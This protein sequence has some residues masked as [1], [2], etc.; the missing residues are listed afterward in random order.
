MVV[1]TC[2]RSQTQNTDFMF[3]SYLYPN[4]SEA[5]DL[6][7]SSLNLRSISRFYILHCSSPSPLMLVP[8][9]NFEVRQLPHHR[10]QVR[11][12]RSEGNLQY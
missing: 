2:I 10:H 7:A 3:F 1:M 4:T 11:N 5:Y 8:R 9:T 6:S 12:H